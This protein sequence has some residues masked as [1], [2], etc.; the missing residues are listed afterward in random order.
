METVRQTVCV[1]SA[2]SAG[3][4][5]GSG[6]KLEDA[7]R[8]V[9]QLMYLAGDPRV[10][11]RV[12][13]VPSPLEEQAREQAAQTRALGR[14]ALEYG[15]DDG[16]RGGWKMV[17]REEDDGGRGKGAKGERRAGRTEKRDAV[18]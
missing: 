18:T 9:A 13:V 6:M 1:S 17:M 16:G 14:R 8:R 7:C 5:R 12:A 4:T 15:V 2:S 10:G 11:R 3:A